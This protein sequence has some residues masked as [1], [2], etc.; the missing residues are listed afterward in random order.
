MSSNRFVTLGMPPTVKGSVR[1]DKPVFSDSH[2][3]G[4]RPGNLLLSLESASVA[5][6]PAAAMMLCPQACP[7]PGRASYSDI[8]ATSQ[9]CF[10]ESPKEET[11]A[12]SRP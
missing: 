9:S 3:L 6:N 12:V 10:F 7:I 1:V 4:T 2:S 8:I 11:K 5:P